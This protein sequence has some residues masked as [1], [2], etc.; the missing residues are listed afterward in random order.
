MTEIFKIKYAGVGQNNRN[1]T[2]T[3]YISLLRSEEMKAMMH[4]WV[5][6]T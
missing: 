1:T 6:T 3:V 2:D 5:Q 4:K